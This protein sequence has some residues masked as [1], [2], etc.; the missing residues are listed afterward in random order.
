M[1]K[2][3]I[4]GLIITLVLFIIQIILVLYNRYIVE[5]IHNKDLKNIKEIKNRFYIK[6]NRQNE[7]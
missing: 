4:I 1:D 3:I 7:R 2:D 5:E 6:N